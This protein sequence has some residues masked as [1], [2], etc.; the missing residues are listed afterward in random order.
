M[1]QQIDFVGLYNCSKHL[2]HLAEGV[3]S[4]LMV[5]Q[6]L[7]A[8]VKTTL[9]KPSTKK[10]EEVRQQLVDRLQYRQSVFDSTRLRLRSLEKRTDNA[11]NLAFNLVT[12]QDSMILM[13]DSRSMKTIAALTM[14]FLPTTGVA[15][16]LGSELFVVTEDPSSDGGWIVRQNPLFKAL[17]YISVPLTVA[18]IGLAY[19]FH[20]W[21]RSHAARLGFV[22]GMTRKW[23]VE[24]KG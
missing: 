6:R 9:G 21:T 11:A 24:R 2:I 23:G 14:V 5:V 19:L 1:S 7:L 17:W 20:W 16:V 13:Q 22:G 3:D 8:H 4:A 15:T 12:Q 10:R 18:V